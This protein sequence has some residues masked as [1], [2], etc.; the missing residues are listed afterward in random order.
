MKILQ[1]F[2]LLQIKVTYELL[3]IVLR[4]VTALW[5]QFSATLRRPPPAHAPAAERLAPADFPRL[6]HQ[7]WTREFGSRNPNDFRQCF[8]TRGLL[9]EILRLQLGVTVELM[10]GPFNQDPDMPLR[11]SASAEDWIFGFKHDSLHHPGTGRP[12]R[13]ITVLPR[14]LGGLLALYANPMYESQLPQLLTSAAQLMADGTDADKAIRLFALVPFCRGRT[15]HAGLARSGGQA[16]P[17][18]YT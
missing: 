6:L 14:F 5:T 15:M 7:T 9:L 2:F 1:S 16:L 12:R 13:W 8:A 18:N 10:A 17:V 3:L 4:V 11:F